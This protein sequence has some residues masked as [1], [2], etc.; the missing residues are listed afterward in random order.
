M[1]HN[2][3]SSTTVHPERTE[4]YYRRCRYVTLVIHIIDTSQPPSRQRGDT[5]FENIHYT[6]LRYSSVPQATDIVSEP[7][8]VLASCAGCVAQIC[9]RQL[10]WEPQAVED[11]GHL[12]SQ[13]GKIGLGGTKRAEW[14]GRIDSQGI[15]P[16]KER[17]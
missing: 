1:V 14:D 11:D 9:E 4:I 5:Y 10:Q 17:Q 13:S 8:S 3:P 7:C 2:R 12:L 6:I 15:W 16:R